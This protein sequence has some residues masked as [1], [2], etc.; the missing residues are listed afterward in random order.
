[1]LQSRLS[2]LHQVLG[3]L[4][5]GVEVDTLFRSFLFSFAAS[6]TAIVAA[7]IEFSALRVLVLFVVFVVSAP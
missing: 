7:E 3:L 6:D 5:L 4:G 1:M 2:G